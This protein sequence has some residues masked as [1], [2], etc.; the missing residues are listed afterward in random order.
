[1]KFNYIQH[2][3]STEFN[4]PFEELRHELGIFQAKCVT[5]TTFNWLKNTIDSFKYKLCYN[6]NLSESEII[7]FHKINFQQMYR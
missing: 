1:M 4:Y 6:F 7:E 2:Y 3:N 5:S